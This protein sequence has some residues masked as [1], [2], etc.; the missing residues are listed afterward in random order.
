MYPFTGRRHRRFLRPQDSPD[1]PPESERI[2]APDS[3]SAHWTPLGYQN[4]PLRDRPQA[5]L[6]TYQ[7]PTA[8]GRAFPDLQLL[9]GVSELNPRW[10]TPDTTDPY[11][12]SRPTQNPTLA[13]RYGGRAQ[14]TPGALT[15]QAWQDQ[16][17]GG[18]P[19]VGSGP[20]TMT[21]GARILQVLGWSA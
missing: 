15:T 21:M 14:Q 19:S 16:F 2:L 10:Y 18:T 6:R 9:N 11:W 1:S 17:Y 4:F 20:G 7:F 13:Q 8:I 12:Q 3:S 5:D